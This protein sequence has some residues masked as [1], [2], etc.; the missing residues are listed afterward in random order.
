MLEGVTGSGKTFTA[1]NV[2]AR[3]AQP[4]LVVSHNKT[5]AAQLYGELKEFFP[6]NAAE[7]FVSYYDYYQPEAYIPQ[8]DTYI[9]KDA[10]INKEIE[11]LRLSATNSLL[12]RSDVVIVASVS[13]IYGLGSPS[14][15]AEM[16]VDVE[17]GQVVERDDVLM[18]LV[19]VQYTR[20]DYEPEQGTFRVRGDAVDIFPPYSKTGIRIDF[21]GDEVDSVSE[22]DALTGKRLR[23]L[24]R[25]L[26]SPAKHFVMPEAK[27][28]PA[29]GR[30]LAELEERVGWFEQQ[31]KLIEAQRLQQR[32]MYD[33]E[34]MKEIGYC[35]GIE[36]YSRHLSGREEGEPPATLL[37]YFRGDF[38]TII[39][40]SHVTIP[41]LRGM[42]N[43]DQSRKSVL[44]EH[45]FRLP[46]AKDNRPLNFEE[47]MSATG[48][49]M[50]TTATPAPYEISLVPAP[51]EQIIRPT[52][53]LDPTV[54]VRPLV[55]QIDDLMEEVRHHAERRER[56][57][58][59][60]L[61]KRTAEDLAQYL[62]NSG[63]RVE[64]LHSEIDALDRVDVLRRLRKGEFDCL[65]GIN[66]LREGLDLPEV[67]LVAILDADKEG[68]LRSETSLIQVAGRTA[69]HVDGKVIL[70][71]DSQTNSMRRM[72]EVTARRRERQMDHNE[73]H[74]ITPRSIQRKIRE[75]L[76]VRE[77][78]RELD[79]RVVRESG[80]DYDVDRAIQEMEAEMMEAAGALE[81]ERAAVL[82]DQIRELKR[83]ADGAVSDDA[84]A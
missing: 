60:T 7:Y 37:D 27:V 32:T 56:V 26:V 15:Y 84:L 58:V 59:T 42:Y 73:R 20:N 41:Q 46:S 82:R 67:S 24:E 50:F 36:N 76:L 53:L 48:R 4:T 45:G 8:T 81:F 57:L 10:S 29:I 51:V 13:C 34:M 78:A 68:F 49:V 2:I 61:T 17:K 16:L 31:G 9:E 21:F 69:R 75:G 28:L 54:E 14:D 18:K 3:L 1:A 22:I 39:D 70:Y 30:I 44:V 74:G 33:V 47:F 25:A 66:L 5:L 83:S 62:R 79:E 43:A 65:V 71:A 80:A 52:G 77:H 63:L 72:M 11:R 6:E 40:E 19:N 38:F 55:D 35:S 12:S 64:Y 23:E